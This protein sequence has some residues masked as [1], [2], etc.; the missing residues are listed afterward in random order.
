MGI[1]TR[2]F[3][4]KKE[5]EESIQ[6]IEKDLLKLKERVKAE[7][8]AIFGVGGRLKGLPLVYAADDE[9][10]L[11]QFSARLYE[12]IGPIKFLSEQRTLRDF[13]INY[14]DSI[15]FYKQILTNIG[16]FAI[17]LDK[18]DILTV[19]QWVYKKESTLKDLLHK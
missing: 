12:L 13:V 5:E 9:P 6:A 7:M 10:A 8:I 14:H 15:L 11:K 3:G 17:L 18:E 16:F 1:L 19:K 2:I 4:E